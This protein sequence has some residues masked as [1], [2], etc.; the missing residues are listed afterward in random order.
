M[1]IITNNPVTMKTIIFS[2]MLTGMFA[3]ILGQ[4]FSNNMECFMVTYQAGNEAYRTGNYP[5]AEA[6]YNRECNLVKSPVIG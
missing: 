2:I 6:I 5:E 1:K 3:S 4:P